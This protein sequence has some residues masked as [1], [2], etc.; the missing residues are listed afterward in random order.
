MLRW[1]TLPF[2]RRQRGALKSGFFCKTNQLDK[3]I[4]SSPSYLSWEP[5]G[6]GP[7]SASPPQPFQCSP[8]KKL[9]IKTHKG[10]DTWER[11]MTKAKFFSHQG[12]E[13]IRVGLVPLRGKLVLVH[14]QQVQKLKIH[15][16]ISH[17]YRY[18][19]PFPHTRSFMLEF[20]GQMVSIVMKSCSCVK[21]GHFRNLETL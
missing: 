3:L 20:F 6:T 11:L 12:L 13:Q 2:G 17:K 21:G 14:F 15:K 19:L 9:K 5:F 18:K 4:I 7:R 8:F 16:G 10:N 1:R